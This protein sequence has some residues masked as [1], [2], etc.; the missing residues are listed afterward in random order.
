M[1]VTGGSFTVEKNIKAGLY[2][3][4]GLDFFSV[5]YNYNNTANGQAFSNN[6][7]LMLPVTLKKYY[8]VGKRSHI[9][10]DAGFAAAWYLSSKEDYENNTSNKKSNLGLNAGLFVALGFKTQLTKIISFDAGFKSFQDY[11]YSYKN[12]TDKLTIKS[13]TLITSFYFDIK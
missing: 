6:N 8:M 2:I 1:L 7:F 9:F 12:T 3:T 5:K 11:L 4:S 10:F 13:N